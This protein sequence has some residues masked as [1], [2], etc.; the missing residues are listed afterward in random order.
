[1]FVLRRYNRLGAL[2]N[3]A[4]ASAT[5]GEIPCVMTQPRHV[6]LLMRLSRSTPEMFNSR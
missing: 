1:M 2:L 4:D 5:R 3:Q 6:T